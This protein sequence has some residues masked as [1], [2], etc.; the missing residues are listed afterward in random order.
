VAALAV[1][2]AVVYGRGRLVEAETAGA[3]CFLGQYA[4][5]DRYA[6]AAALAFALVLVALL[7]ARQPRGW[8]LPA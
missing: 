1:T 4:R 3:S 6:E 5:G 8:L 7:A 2:P